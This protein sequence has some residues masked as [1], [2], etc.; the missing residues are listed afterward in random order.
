MT[1]ASTAT[2][3]MRC[4]RCVPSISAAPGSLTSDANQ[5]SGRPTRVA[6]FFHGAEFSTPFPFSTGKPGELLQ[7]D[8]RF[9]A[10]VVGVDGM[11]NE[12]HLELPG[13]AHGMLRFAVFADVL[14][15]HELDALHLN[16]PAALIPVRR[17]GHGLHAPLIFHRCGR[18]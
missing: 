2:A 14:G 16:I 9:A 17:Q 12:A 4:A 10:A 15:H 8:Y 5:K 11:G 6:R 3:A 18:R 13:R 1:G 7:V